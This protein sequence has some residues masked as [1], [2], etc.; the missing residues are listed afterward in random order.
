MQTHVIRENRKMAA[1]STAR[2]APAVMDARQSTFTG[3]G[4]NAR[5]LSEVINLRSTGCHKTG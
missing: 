5:T 3:Q 2:L 4:V 1:R